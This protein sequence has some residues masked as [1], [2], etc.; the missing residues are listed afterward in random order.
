MPTPGKDS[1]DA[2]ERPE[3]VSRRRGVAPTHQ[4]DPHVPSD[5]QALVQLQRLAGNQAVQEL[6]AR[7]KGI[8]QRPDGDER[9]GRGTAPVPSAP[10]EGEASSGEEVREPQPHQRAGE[11]TARDLAAHLRTVH[12]VA[13]ALAARAVAAA[14]AEGIGE[15]QPSGAQTGVEPAVRGVAAHLRTV[16]PVARADPAPAVAKIGRAHV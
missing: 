13:G 3:H 7:R 11:S 4:R 6:L 2:R 1:S 10:A 15:R 12:P 5:L 14:P 9:E 8:E 16:H